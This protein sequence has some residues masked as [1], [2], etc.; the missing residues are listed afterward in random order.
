MALVSGMFGLLVGIGLAGF[1]G[2]RLVALPAM[3]LVAAV[4]LIGVPIFTAYF[5]NFLLPQLDNFAPNF[6]KNKPIRSPNRE[7]RILAFGIEN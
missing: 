5:K 7:N 1:V 2:W 3:C 6:N 4:I